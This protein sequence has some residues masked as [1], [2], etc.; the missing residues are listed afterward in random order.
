MSESHQNAPSQQESLEI[1]NEKTQQSAEQNI[2]EKAAQ[3][4]QLER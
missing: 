4:E 1:D 2:H 3:L